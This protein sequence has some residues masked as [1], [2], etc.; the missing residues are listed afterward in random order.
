MT[1]S[2]VRVWNGSAWDTIKG[3]Q[4]SQ[5]DKGDSAPLNSISIGSVTTGEPGTSAAAIITG[6]APSQTLSLTIP[7]GN[8][9]ATGAAGSDATATTPGGSSG[10]VQIN[11]GGVFAGSEVYWNGSPLQINCTD[12]AAKPLIIRGAPGQS[13]L[14]TEWQ[15]SAGSTFAFLSASGSFGATENIISYSGNVMGR[16]NA[17]EGGWNDQGQAVA[18]VRGSSANGYASIQIDRGSINQSAGLAMRTNGVYEWF[19]GPTEGITDFRVYSFA[20][21]DAIVVYG[22]GYNSPGRQQ[23]FTRDAGSVGL[24]VLC[25]P[26][27]TAPPV[28]VRDAS[29]NVKVSI[30]PS[31]D[32]EITNPNAGP[33]LHSPDGTR[34]R[35]QVANGGGLI[36][37]PVI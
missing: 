17:F 12:P 22:N 34:Y 13:G 18:Y 16:F 25:A 4:G 27:Q 10:Q 2:D 35:L 30:L 28:R 6:V 5:G 24:D 31:G 19:F 37:T 33:I 32:V 26:G 20:L 21:G 29:G 23:I 11:N 8:T 9:G 1:I 7:A 3:A 36:T 14:I 15:T